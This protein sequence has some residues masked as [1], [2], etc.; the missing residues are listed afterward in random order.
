M[1]I[2]DKSKKINYKK[3]E[4]SKTQKIVGTFKLEKKIKPFSPIKESKLNTNHILT[5][6]TEVKSKE[7]SKSMKQFE[8]FSSKKITKI[9]KTNNSFKSGK[10][11]NQKFIREFNFI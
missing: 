10:K 7:S 11:G 9:I 2:T 5:P 8:N 1:N 3:K 4:S 6:K